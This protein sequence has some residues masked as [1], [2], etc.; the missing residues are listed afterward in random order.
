[1][2]VCTIRVLGLLLILS[3]C[4]VDLHAATG[5]EVAKLLNTRYQNTTAECVGEHPAY[6]CSGVLLR[7]SA[8]AGEFWTHNATATQLGA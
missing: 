6:F 1:M 7:G 3:A 8:E 5:P 2:R 4:T